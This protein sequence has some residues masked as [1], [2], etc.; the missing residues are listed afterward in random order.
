MPF[1]IAKP[2]YNAPVYLSSTWAAYVMR[3]EAWKLTCI[4]LHGTVVA[5]VLKLKRHIQLP[6]SDLR[7]AQF[8]EGCWH[9]P[10]RGESQEVDI[11]FSS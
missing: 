9:N 4:A 8:A 7:L 11:C 1:N 2:L 3:C 6:R 10:W 5:H